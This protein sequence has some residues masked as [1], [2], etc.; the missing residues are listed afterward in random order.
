MGK[1]TMSDIQVLIF[2]YALQNAVRFKGRANNKAV[3]GKIMSEHPELRGRS[4][5]FST[6]ISEII[7]KVNIMG[8]KK[9]RE[10]LE[11]IAPNLLERKKTKV[12]N[13]TLSPLENADKE[14]VMRMA[15][16][17]SGP[18]H[19]GNA[20]M[21][22]LNDEY[23]KMYNGKLILF[24]DDTIGTTGKTAITSVKGKTRFLPTKKIIPEAYE[25]IKD[26]LRWINIKWHEEY[27]KSDRLEIYYKY[28]EKL[29][30][31]E[32]AYICTCDANQFRNQY[33][34]LRKNCPCRTNTL[35]KNLLKW[36]KMLE[37]EYNSGEAVVRLKTSMQH[38]DPALRDVVLMRI[39]TLEHPRV[40]N[41]Y[42]VWPLLEFS[43]AIDD[44]LLGITH[45]LRGKDLIKEDYIEKYIWKYFNWPVK[46]FIHY[47]SFHLKGGTLSKT[48][49]RLL[50]EKGDYTGWDDPRTWSLQSLRKRGFNPIVLREFLLSFGLSLAEVSCSPENL[51]AKNREK[52]D[53]VANRYF[54][55]AKPIDFKVEGHPKDNLIARI[56][57]HPDYPER[58]YRTLKLSTSNI[59][60]AE[61]D[62]YILKEN[63]IVRLKDLFNV[64]YSRQGLLKYSDN[65]T[66]IHDIPK[67]HWLPFES[68]VSVEVIMPD[69]KVE[70]GVGEESL[71]N[72]EIGTLLQFERFG[73][74]RY[75]ADRRFYF[76][77]K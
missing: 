71:K 12:E 20:R 36:Q 62:V 53:P 2:K 41:K 11:N 19:I 29:I 16:Y 50:I 26:G 39:S 15:P 35:Q 17:P 14:I 58:G 6:S 46:I 24:F 77:H 34:V 73:F 27:Y 42:K 49:L 9:Q 7:N 64:E 63:K 1:V 23:T 18:L 75:E 22:V 33:K 3:L 70:K 54:F 65:Q 28:C 38:K 8:L 74:V 72:I 57:V 5:E 60:V 55:V 59:L 45:I 40:G 4:Q 66:S 31:L 32:G 48:R 68:N 13:K 56:P 30:Q 43:W 51:Y 37:G 21:T 52:I 61:K 47:G 76:T 69:G 10:M 67:I 44:Y 25:M